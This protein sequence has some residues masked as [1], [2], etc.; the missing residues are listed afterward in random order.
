MMI[1]RIFSVQDG[2]GKIQFE[3]SG[4]YLIDHR[5]LREI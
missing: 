4:L 3:S 2:C 1:N 5:I